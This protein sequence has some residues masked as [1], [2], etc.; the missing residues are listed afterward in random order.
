VDEFKRGPGNPFIIRLSSP[1]G[2]IL[3]V[4]VWPDF[5]CPLRSIAATSGAN[6]QVAPKD[7]SGWGKIKWGMTMADV[8]AAYKLSPSTR[9]SPETKAE[10]F[11]QPMDYCLPD[12]GAHFEMDPVDVGDIHMGVTVESAYGSP[13][14]NAVRLSDFLGTPQNGI[15]MRHFEELK[16]MLLQK[17]G[18]AA[19][20][21][22]KTDEIGASVATTLWTFPSTA[23]ILSLR[24]RSV[25]Y[26]EYRAGKPSDKL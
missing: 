18:P 19:S 11:H 9:E 13:R 10:C 14:V 2:R 21:E 5:G 8:K 25:V 22:T 16:I 12:R 17:Y 26:L 6:A 20:Q 4:H 24:E 7:V 3:G 15:G 23:I 1:V